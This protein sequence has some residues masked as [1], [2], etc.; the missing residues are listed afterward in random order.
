MIIMFTELQT[1][2]I[3]FHFQLS[4]LKMKKFNLDSPQILVHKSSRSS[5]LSKPIP[6]YTLS[7]EPA[8]CRSEKFDQLL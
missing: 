3:C 1:V 7:L 2:Q 4:D 6:A 5:H 8:K